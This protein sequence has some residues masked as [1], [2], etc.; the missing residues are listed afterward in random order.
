MICSHFHHVTHNFT[1]TKEEKIKEKT[2]QR[3]TTK[4]KIFQWSGRPNNAWY[5]PRYDS[6]KF[7]NEDDHIMVMIIV[8]KLP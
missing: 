2:T 1:E 4:S 5:T 6:L 3:E 7:F 8:E